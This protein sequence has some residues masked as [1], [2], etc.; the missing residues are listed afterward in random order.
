[1]AKEK[2]QAAAYSRTAYSKLASRKTALPAK[3]MRS[4]QKRQP[5]SASRTPGLGETVAPQIEFFRFL[6]SEQRARQEQD[7]PISV[8]MLQAMFESWQHPACETQEPSITRLSLGDV[9]AA[10]IAGA[11]AQAGKI[12]LYLNSGAVDIGD[13]SGC[14][15]LAA[16]LAS[17]LRHEAVVVGCSKSSERPFAAQIK[18]LLSAYRALMARGYAA[19][20]ITLAADAL[21]AKLVLSCV[22]AMRDFHLPLPGNV[23]VMTPWLDAESVQDRRSATQKGCAQLPSA[24]AYEQVPHVA[25]VQD[26]L[27]ANYKGFPRLYINVGAVQGL[28]DN[29]LQERAQKLY[30]RAQRAGVE[31][32]L[33]V[34][35]GMHHAFPFLARQ[36]P[37]PNS[38]LQN[39]SRWFA[40][41]ETAGAPMTDE[42]SR[43]LCIAQVEAREA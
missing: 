4:A 35:D 10:W 19:H 43:Q 11:D 29:Q 28:L 16:N 12:M 15:K 13:R 34:V 7:N 8:P 32:C 21:G 36:M 27:R 2:M 39:I 42:A 1:M 30:A 5:E 20:N 40:A 23:L 17:T 38:E 24:I 18:D 41:A 33:S 25:A 22:L 14:L 9:D 26:V 6:R 37:E 31:V 3:P